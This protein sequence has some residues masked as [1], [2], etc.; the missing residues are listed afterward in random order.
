MNHCRASAVPQEILLRIFALCNQRDN[1]RN[2]RV[3]KAWKEAALDQ[4]WRILEEWTQP[5]FL[6]LDTPARW[7]Q[8]GVIKVRASDLF[9]SNLS[10]PCIL[11]E[12]EKPPY[13]GLRSKSHS[14][15]LGST[16]RKFL[17][18]QAH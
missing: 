8:V 10:L 7:P 5:L 9:S 15:G 4:V 12:A 3:C 11:I 14:R 17:S 1:A 6:K 18:S 16:C 2:A 13:S